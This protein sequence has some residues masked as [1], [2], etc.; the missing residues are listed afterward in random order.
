MEE[1]W[2]KKD[3]VGKRVLYGWRRVVEDDIEN[4]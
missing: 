3:G 2:V 1:V 4:E